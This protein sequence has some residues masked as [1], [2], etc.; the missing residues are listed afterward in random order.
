M[1]TIKSQM[2]DSS[3]SISAHVITEACKIYLLKG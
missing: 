3:R 2:H 1:Y